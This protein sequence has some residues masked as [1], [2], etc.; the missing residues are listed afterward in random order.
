MAEFSSRTE[1][2]MRNVVMSGITQIF[3]I[4]TRF[5]IQ[6]IFIRK[7][8]KDYTGINGLFNNVILVLNLSEL[9]VGSAIVFSLYQALHERSVEKISGLMNFYRK[10]YHVIGGVIALVG[11]LIIPFL[12]YMIK[13]KSVPHT[14]I[15]YLLFLFNTVMSYFFSFK[16]MLLTADQREYLNQ[17]NLLLFTA[18]QIMFQFI[19]LLVF[20]A[21][22]AYLLIFIFFQVLSNLVISQKVDQ[23]YPFLKENRH[24]KISQ[25]EFLVIKRNTKE[26]MGDKL[27]EVVIIGTDN[28]LLSAMIGLNAIGIFSSYE[29]IVN[30]LAKLFNMV[31]GGASAS[32]GNLA[33]AIKDKKKV[34]QNFFYHSGISFMVALFTFTCL[35]NLLQPFILLWA[36]E[37]YLVSSFT[38]W[39]IVFNLALQIMRNTP[40]AFFSALGTYQYMG[41]KSFIE[42]LLNLIFSATLLAKTDLGIGAVVLGT[43]LANILVNSWWEPYQL[44]RLYFKEGYVKYLVC[45]YVRVLLLLGTGGISWWLLNC[46]TLHNLIVRLFVSFI[47]SI[48]FASMTAFLSSYREMKF[49]F[50]NLLKFRR[51]F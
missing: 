37:G 48:L 19:A 43:I 46:W 16:R 17:V 13:G 40:A 29:L 14:M 7:L 2:A 45:Y 8:G 44:Y 22:I 26:L 5:I 1:K 38:I 9:G 50:E 35:L 25:G 23:L 18:I 12:P 51:K 31:I 4:T 41:R 10:V 28:I 27:S 11:L 20:K 33:H 3:I 15:I 36:G 34:E 42:S 47:I 32:V 49:V 39:L 6:T 21:Y 24:A 30:A